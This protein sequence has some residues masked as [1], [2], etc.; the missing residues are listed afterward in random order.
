MPKEQRRVLTQDE[1]SELLGKHSACYVC[2][3]TLEGYSPEEIQFDH[4]Y[5]YA[6]GHP[7]ELSNF[8][9]VH[10]SKDPRKLNCH[11]AK[12]RKTPYEYREEYSGPHNSDNMLR[13]R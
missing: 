7:Q 8:A 5:N 2:L 9:P 10:A 1:E 6:D 3:K 11:K 4:I 13:Y 12:G